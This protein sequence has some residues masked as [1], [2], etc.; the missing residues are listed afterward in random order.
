MKTI[1]IYETPEEFFNAIGARERPQPSASLPEPD[2]LSCLLYSESSLLRYAEATAKDAIASERT[3]AAALPKGTVLRWKPLEAG[4]APEEFFE[5]GEEKGTGEFSRLAD[6]R[7]TFVPSDL[8]GYLSRAVDADVSR[9][10]LRDSRVILRKFAELG[11]GTKSEA[12]G[13]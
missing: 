6:V 11:E 9:V 5:A 13:E 4:A 12:P 8:A 3:N 10:I 2:D 7:L 1:T